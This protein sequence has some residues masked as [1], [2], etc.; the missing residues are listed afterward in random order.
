MEGGKLEYL[1]MIQEPICRMS[2]ISA[3]FKGFA[4]TIVA[5]IAALTYCEVNIW[6][7]GLSFLPVVVFVFLD[8]YYLK[9]EK[10]YR[11]LYEQVRIGEHEVD[12]SMQLTRDN[13]VAESRVWD[14]IKSPSIWLFYP[15]MFVILIIVFIFKMRGVV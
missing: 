11:F 1:Q 6:V 14:C 8:I 3:I 10:K 4:A 12:F 15:I 2:T 9:I 7:L 5:G 13:A